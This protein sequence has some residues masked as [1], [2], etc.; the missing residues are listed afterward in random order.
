MDQTELLKLLDLPG[1]SS[2]QPADTGA[3]VRGSG[4]VA[5]NASPT[6]LRVDAWG[7]RR[8]RDL[9]AESDRLRAA[10]TD[11]YTAADCFVA[12]FDPDPQL[13]EACV[14]PRR[15]EFLAQLLDTPDYKGLHTATRLDD[16]AAAI[17]AAHFAEQF[18]R[19]KEDD[20]TN[21]REDAATESPADAVGREVATLRAVGRALAEA[22]KDVDELKD[23]ASA[24]GMGPGSPG[25][26]DPRVVAELFKRVRADPALRR[27]CELAGRFR[28]VAQSRQRRKA[29]HGLD[30]VVGV[31]LGGDLS[32]L[33]PAELVRLAEPAFEDE[34]LL[35]LVEKRCLCRDHRA[36]EPVGKGPIIVVCDESGSMDGDKAH[37]AKALAL[38]LAWIARRQKRWCGLVAYSGDTG[39][40]L[41][42][43]PPGRW[44]ETALC[45]WLS[46]FLGGGSDL[47]VPVREMPD[48]Y[49]RLGAPT[50][51][52]DLVFITDA[53]CRIPVDIKNRFLEWRKAIQARLVTLVLNAAAGDLAAVSDEVFHVTDL[54]PTHE[55]VGRVLSL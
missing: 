10:G 47:D 4:T 45:D 30:D 24:L 37:A 54:D 20:K 5:E 42:V 3:V 35:R 9:V 41:L 15:R 51:I 11:E 27:I 21:K 36:V 38:A 31:T 25:S 28:C 14:D 39:E 32:R 7:L 50:G 48:Y 23:T 44:D 2:D 46:E 34:M 8:G 22:G 12:A 53:V 1:K 43:L 6:A 52:T 17:A 13:L 26:H 29:D 18:A 19:L 33:L 49:Q 16:T 55:A 40:R